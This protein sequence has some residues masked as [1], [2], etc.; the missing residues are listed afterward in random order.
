MIIP[1]TI[2]DSG[3]RYL[4]LT[5]QERKFKK[6]KKIQI[7]FKSISLLCQAGLG[8]VCGYL[9]KAPGDIAQYVSY[10]AKVATF[11]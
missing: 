2:F 7:L 3:K 11:S 1:A 5:D 4:R 10:C 8:L 6:F 9:R